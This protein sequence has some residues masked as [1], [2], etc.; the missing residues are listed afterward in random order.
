MNRCIVVTVEPDTDVFI[1]WCYENNIH[2]MVPAFCRWRKSPWTFDPTSK[3]ANPAFC[4][5]RSFH[6]LSDILHADPAPDYEVITGTIG[7]A[8]GSELAGFLRIWEQL[9]DLD[10]LL[11]KAD[12]YPVPRAMDVAIATLY[13]LM[14]RATEK[15]MSQVLKYFARNEIEL[16]CVGIKDLLNK[17]KMIATL[18]VMQK[19]MSD[20][21]NVR[22]L[23]GV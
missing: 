16:A 9:P 3:S 22:L 4:S 15:N 2:P 12:S 14:A 20:P 17:D 1:E 18:P 8:T 21:R 7:D 13:A 10:K 6:I 11:K 23:T 19:W 5:P